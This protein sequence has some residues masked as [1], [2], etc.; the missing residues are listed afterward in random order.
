M[1][2]T[3]YTPPRGLTRKLSVI[4]AIGAAILFV[5]AFVTPERIWANA[6]VGSYYVVTLGL[7]GGAFIALCAVCGANWNAAFR[8][9]PETIAKTLPI[10]SVVLLVVI[11]I[12]LPG[13]S[14]HHHGEGDAGTF[15]FKELWLNTAFFSV[16]SVVYVVLWML[17]ARLMVARSQQPDLMAGVRISCGLSALFLAI[18]GVTLSLASADWI[19]ALEPMW[20][21]T[22]W[23]VYHFSGLV[24]SVL[25]VM[26]IACIA[27]RKAGPLHGIFKDEHLHDLGKLLIGFSCF[28]MYIWFSQYMLIWYSNI[29]EETSYFILRATGAWGPIVIGS[30]VLNWVIPFFALLPKRNKRNES[31][32][33]KIAVVILIGRWVDLYVMVFPPVVGTAPVFGIWELATAAVSVGGSGLLF[34]YAFAGKSR[35]S[36]FRT[37]LADG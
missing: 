34:L 24:M 7:G 25:A 3:S 31:A 35:Q 11:A 12:R 23:G 21:S 8:Q 17:F 5:G 14:W 33:L 28:W 9:V 36:V 29:P 2:D 20:F 1:K 15:W 6:F 37:S 13:Y 22:I 19:M 16:R 32:M 30:I 18:F 26:I 10:A 4:T 27:L